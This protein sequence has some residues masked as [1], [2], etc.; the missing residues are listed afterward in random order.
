MYLHLLSEANK[1]S[2]MAI[3]RAVCAADG[4]FSD[5]ERFMLEV[6]A[7]EM[8][9]SSIESTIEETKAI[10]ILAETGTNQEKRIVVMELVGLSLADSDFSAEERAFLQTIVEKFNISEEFVSQCE[11]AVGRYLDL[12]NEFNQLVGV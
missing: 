10:T 9:L 8:G 4:N 12:Q 11:N 2:F 5:S 1:A 7:K 6:Y 3:A